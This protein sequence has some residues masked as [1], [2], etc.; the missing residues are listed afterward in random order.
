MISEERKAELKSEISHKINSGQFSYGYRP[1]F[2]FIGVERIID[3]WTSANHVDS[4]FIKQEGIPMG[5]EIEMEFRDGYVDDDY[6][7]EDYDEDY[8]DEV[9]DDDVWRLN[10]KSMDRCYI[11][12]Y[13]DDSRS[14]IT[15]GNDDMVTQF[16]Y[17]KH[18]GSLNR[19]TE[20]VSQPLTLGAWSNIDLN[21]ESIAGKALGYHTTTAGMHIHMPKGAFKDTQ[22]FIWLHLLE[23]LALTPV[24]HQR[25][26]NLISVIGQ[27]RFNNWARFEMPT[28]SREVKSK[29]AHVAMNR[30]DEEEQ[31][32]KFINMVPRSTIELR[33]FRSNLRADR[34]L[35]NIEF[36][37]S[38]YEYTAYLDRDNMDYMESINAVRSAADWI[39]WVKSDR[40]R[41]PNL[42]EYISKYD[43]RLDDNLYVKAINEFDYEA[44]ESMDVDQKLEAMTREGS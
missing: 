41:Y 36:V 43:V 6:Y 8:P 10:K 28:T 30:R 11:S 9:I 34:V 27:R 44:Y 13:R 29:M 42:S 16:F 35:K 21:L 32:Y 33:F 20:L 39:E 7:D 38:L 19:G 3:A 17:H 26:P 40:T 22:L 23:T 31:R 15:K 25:Y 24:N 4:Q 14:D 5:I 1:G 37:D 12:R 18:D 2:K